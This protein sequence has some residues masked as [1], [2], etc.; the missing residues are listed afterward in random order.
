DIQLYNDAEEDFE[1][2]LELVLASGLRSRGESH[3]SVQVKAG[4][5]RYLS[6]KLQSQQLSLLKDEE[7]LVKINTSDGILLLHKTIQLSVAE[8][9][10]VVVMDNSELQYLQE[11][12]DSV[13]VK[14][15]VLNNGTTDEQ[16]RLVL[17]SPDRMGQ[18]DF[19]A[20]PLS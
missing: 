9:R 15:R 20:V 11:V 13:Y 3:I 7:L 10:S 17:S 8:N 6:I 14:L 16:V 4:K 18:R 2:Q 19:K 1:G 12:G 5:K